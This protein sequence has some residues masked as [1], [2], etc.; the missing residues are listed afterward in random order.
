MKVGGPAEPELHPPRILVVE[1]DPESREMMGAVLSLWGYETRLVAAGPAALDAAE[2]E[3]PDIVLLDI[4]LPGMD[5]FE[6]ARCLR[7][8]PGGNLLF[9]AAV[10]AYHSEEYRRKARAA[11]FDRYLEKPIDVD[12]LRQVLSQLSQ[13]LG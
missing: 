7:R 8:R 5:G 11:G 12:L 6:V 4:G 10:T 1:D 9:I 3:V 2:Q 13:K